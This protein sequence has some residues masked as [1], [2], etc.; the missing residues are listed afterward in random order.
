MLTLYR[1][2]V[3]FI[4]FSRI[5][6]YM[7]W[8][9]TC[10]EYYG[11]RKHNRMLYQKLQ[12]GKMGKENNRVFDVRGGND[13]LLPQWTGIIM[14]PS[15]G[16]RSFLTFAAWSGQE[17]CECVQFSSNN[18]GEKGGVKIDRGWNAASRHHAAC[19]NKFCQPAVE[20]S[21]RLHTLPNPNRHCKWILI[22][23]A[24][25]QIMRL[26]PPTSCNLKCSVI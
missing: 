4:W 14:R 12:L 17:W 21:E 23:D 13:N 9:I 16:M 22:L 11:T 26:T 10:W 3:I 24:Y 15:L 25:C 2:L 18:R 7:R 5:S 19:F 8:I 1:Y 20:V 6:G